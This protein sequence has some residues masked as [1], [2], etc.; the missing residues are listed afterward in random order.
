M[1]TSQTLEIYK[2][3]NHHFKNEEHTSKIVEYIQQIIDNKFDEKKRYSC[4]KRSHNAY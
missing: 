4:Y 3:L 1:N 2:I